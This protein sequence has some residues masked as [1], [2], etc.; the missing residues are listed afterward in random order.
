MDAKNSSTP[1]THPQPHPIPAV[2]DLPIHSALT[3]SGQGPEPA[4]ETEYWAP[5]Y[6]TNPTIIQDHHH[7]YN[8]AA[9]QSIPAPV[10]SQPVSG[11]THAPT[12]APAPM[13]APAPPIVPEITSYESNATQR[14]QNEPD[15]SKSAPKSTGK[16]VGAKVRKPRKQGNN[17]SQGGRPGTLFW[18]N[19]DQQSVAEGTREETLKM[20][21]SHVMSEHNRKKRLES[22]KRVSDK[23]KSWKNLAF[24]PVETGTGTS[25]GPATATANTDVAGPSRRSSQATAAGRKASTA[26]VQ[27]ARI[28]V[29]SAS[30]PRS[31]YSETQ[32]IFEE[33]GT[34][35]AG[36]GTG[37]PIVTGA[38]IDDYWL[39]YEGQSFA[40]AQDVSPFTLVGQGSSDPFN[41][42]HTQLSDRMNRHLQHFLCT[43]T[44]LAY[45]LQRRYDAKLQAHWTS[46]VSLDPASLHAC[47]CVSATNT[48]LAIGEFPLTDGKRS[49][50]LL[51]DTYHHRGETIRLVNEGLSDPIKASSDTLIAAVSSLLTVDIVTGDPDYLKIHLAGLRQMV[52]MR[53]SFA[54]VASE[55]RFQISWTDIRVACMALSKPIFPFVRYVRPLNYAVT[56]PTKEL[57]ATASSLMTLAQVPGIFEDSLKQI[58]YDLADLT[59]YAEWVKGA[60]PQ[61][62]EIDDETEAYYNTEVLY[63]E[64]AL[65]R[66]RYTPNG[67]AKGDA[68]IE[69]CVRLAC[70]IF[71]NSAIWE[72]YPDAAPLFLKPI[73][74][75]QTSLE[76]TIR[77][78]CYALCRDLLI[79]L[80]F[81]GSC[82][83]NIPTMRSFFVN[84][85]AAAVRL[86]GVSS[87]QELR[88]VLF[89]YFYADRAYLAPLKALWNELQTVPV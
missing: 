49:S 71:H 19:N 38:S 42:M 66:D 76:S 74:A 56:A 58:I 85:L 22:N 8:Y 57:E 32:P 36:V 83:T 3:E 84:E 53:P 48:A 11:Y 64:Y 30:I 44:R 89:G 34:D 81:I 67:E 70:L 37:Y 12:H 68:S 50:S 77:A 75:L 2:A 61:D 52:G 17:A 40:I 4:T 73:I 45:P 79:W 63:V 5:A 59:W 10:A 23:G 16:A 9:P 46:L 87:W 14:Q 86:H 1:S 65:H 26:T 24:Q 27:T 60:S 33:P 55:I 35:L 20:I 62:D 41:T 47:I 39:G 78:G 31:T 69:G 82:S 88:G 13:P 6:N 28:S 80:L 25:A 15:S 7:Y 29:S 18:V 21:R 51:L 43:L 72:F 54:D